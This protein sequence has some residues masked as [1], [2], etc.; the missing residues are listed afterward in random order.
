MHITVLAEIERRSVDHVLMGSLQKHADLFSHF[1]VLESAMIAN[2]VGNG[3][4]LMPFMGDGVTMESH[5]RAQKLQVNHLIQ[6]YLKTHLPDR[7][8]YNSRIT[9]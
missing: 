8:N 1:L 5:Q 7:Y 9:I 4:N 2:F 3:P 6:I